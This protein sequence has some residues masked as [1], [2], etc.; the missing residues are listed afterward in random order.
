MMSDDRRSGI[1][2]EEDARLIR[3]MRYRDGRLPPHEAE[4]VANEIASDPEAARI[5]EAITAGDIAAR[6][7]WADLESGP[8]PLALARSVS[9]A[10]RASK[11]QPAAFQWRMAAGLV[12]GLALGALGATLMQ[13]GSEHGLRLAGGTG[14]AGASDWKP[15]LIAALQKE[16]ELA[17]VGFG[18]GAASTVAVIRWFA[19][20]TAMHCAEY[21]IATG[22]TADRG[23]IACRKRDGGW[24]VIEQDQ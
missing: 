3:I 16:P 24:D 4:A 19:T 15:A 9:E 17:Q 13:R 1:E 2:T 23:G 5:A 8:V 12:I 11:P 22:G 18:E 7:A 10:A 14:E 6:S 21:T 20:S